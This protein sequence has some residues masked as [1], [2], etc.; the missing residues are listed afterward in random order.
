MSGSWWALGALSVLVGRWA[1]WFWFGLTLTL[2]LSVGICGVTSNGCEPC[3][4]VGAA[5]L[6]IADA[7]S[8]DGRSGGKGEREDL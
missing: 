7:C 1:F 8:S 6:E 3:E 5:L 4:A 2:P